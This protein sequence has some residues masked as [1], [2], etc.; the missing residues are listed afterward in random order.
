M[1]CSK[2][3][4]TALAVSVFVIL[5]VLAAGTAFAVP[6]RPGAAGQGSGACRSHHGELVTL[7]DIPVRLVG[8]TC[9]PSIAP[10]EKNIPLITIVIGFS[11]VPYEDGHNWADTI[12]SGPKSL[13]AYYTDMSFGKF[14]FT[15]AP[16]TAAFGMGDNTNE[17]DAPN[18]GV[19]HV[20]LS[21]EHKN[22][23]DDDENPALAQAIIDALEAADP[24]VDFASFDADHN[25]SISTNELAVGFV[26][27]GY[28][29]AATYT[30][31]LGK[32]KYLWAHAWSV[33]EISRYYNC[34]LS[35]PSPDWVSV[36]SYIAIAEQMDET[37]PEPI[38]VLAH[39]LGH[40]L[41]LPDLYATNKY[42]SSPWYKYSV[43]EYSVMADGSWGT[44]PEGGYIPYS[45]DVWSRWA[46]GWCDPE[47]ADGD[48]VYSV[49][50]Q[51]Y[52]GEEAFSA[53]YIPTQRA[54]EY[55]LLE[56][57]L[58]V[59]WDAGLGLN[60]DNSGVILWHIDDAV[61][62]KYN[63]GNEV[64]NTYHRPAVMPLYP[65]QTKGDY[66]FIGNA[67]YV[68]T[69]QPFFS[70]SF[71]ASLFGENA[72]PLD[73]P[74]YG[75]GSNADNR[76]ARSLSGLKVSFLDNSAPQMTVR[77]S[78]A[79]HVEFLE[80]TPGVEPTCTEP[81]MA[82]C[83]ACTY[84]GAMYLDA[85]GTEPVS[86]PA[87]LAIPAGHDFNA[88]IA[89]NVITV[90]SAPTCQTGG[91]ALVKC[92]RCSETATVEL[93]LD[94][95]N[96][97]FGDWETVTPSTCTVY[98]SE[99]R[100]CPC[101][102]E[103]TRPLTALDPENHTFGDWG[104][105]TPSTCTTYGNEKRVCPC[106]AEETRPLAALD[107]DNHEFGAWETVTPS[108]CISYGNEKRTCPCGAEETRPLT[109]LDPENHEFGAWETVTSSTC[110]TYGSEKRVCPC[111]IEETRPLAALDPGNH[112]FGDWEPGTPS[113]CTTYGNEK[114]TCPCGAEETRLLTELDPDNHTFGEW[115]TVTASTC[116]TKGLLRRA[117]PCGAADEKEL[118]E[119][120]SAHDGGTEVRNVL[121][122]T[123]TEG[124][125]SG[126]TYCVGCGALLASGSTVNAAG[127]RWGE[128]TLFNETTFVRECGVCHVTE[129]CDA[130]PVEKG[131]QC[132]LCGEY[133]GPGLQQRLIGYIHRVFFF[134][135]HLFGVR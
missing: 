25:G 125:Y 34:G 79:D 2:L 54:G 78:T 37:T 134:F 77:L 52:T 18:D 106:G 87:A 17:A 60:H 29:G 20:K 127:H 111:G 105:G 67:T 64:N 89:A 6:A 100:V 45:M 124:G 82:A 56:N 53:V 131:D 117:C 14:T 47:I 4:K 32:E 63:A 22:W 103:E 26:F 9:A 57:R 84:C 15:P 21:S 27:A 86:D 128:W 74:L 66:T 30:Y 76:N 118:E 28:E 3:L 10:T 123:C 41:G 126:D 108:T 24:Y 50:A 129:T 51:S 98:G 130:I 68:L 23:A 93:P 43:S 46:L 44:D 70:A 8:A 99:K 110:T 92:S 1:S 135:V 48:G 69:G 7:D 95:N 107:P 5:L 94:P 31:P 11:N 16:E 65:E 49:N 109:A 80:K 19:V 102:A 75:S 116:H 114:R 90:Y 120:P 72:A 62:E 96:H 39:E 104:P 83:W 73:L 121:P 115:A 12:F 97:V 33:S 113:T 122:A 101:G 55:Y 40:Y 81:G 58:F 119:D 42:S 132:Q 36:D 133:H 112:T 85:E 59:K 61:Y 13:A 38:S 88:G 71:W 35:V 91:S